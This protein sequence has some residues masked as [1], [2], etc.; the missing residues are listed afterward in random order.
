M[1]S[2]LVFFHRCK[3]SQRRHFQLLE[4][5]IAIFILLISFIPILHIYTSIFQQQRLIIRD[6]QLHHLLNSIHVKLTEQL[7]KRIIPFDTLVSQQTLS[8]ADVDSD[9]HRELNQLGYEC[10]YSFVIINDKKKKDVRRYLCQLILTIDETSEKNPFS[11]TH[12]KKESTHSSQPT[13][14]I[15]NKKPTY[16]YFICIFRPSDSSTTLSPQEEQKKENESQLDAD[17]LDGSE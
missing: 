6:N 8:L 4:I 10:T 1:K 7:Y 13:K 2:K 15:N 5:M 9:L 17:Q 16:D 3:Q 14:E 11:W 12:K